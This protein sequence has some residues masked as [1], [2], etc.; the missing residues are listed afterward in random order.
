MSNTKLISLRLPSELL[1]YIDAMAKAEHRSRSQEIVKRLAESSGDHGSAIEGVGE[2]D[3]ERAHKRDGKRARLPVLPQAEGVEK[4]VHSMQPL[5]DELGSGSEHTQ[6]SPL[7]V[8]KAAGHQLYRA[9][10]GW[11][12][13]DCKRSC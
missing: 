4:L 7:E 8:C 5:R 10:D 9:G 3:T 12:C 1:Y 2:L 13:S 6:A 11:Y